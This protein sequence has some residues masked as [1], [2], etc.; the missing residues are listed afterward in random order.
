MNETSENP[1][2]NFTDHC[3]DRRAMTHIPKELRDK[4]EREAMRE[5]PIGILSSDV[6]HDKRYGYLKGA[7]SVAVQLAKAVEALKIISENGEIAGVNI[8]TKMARIALKDYEAWL[9]GEE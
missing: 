7:Q 6:F 2:T 4:I 3:P 1:A 9:K 8:D 5:F